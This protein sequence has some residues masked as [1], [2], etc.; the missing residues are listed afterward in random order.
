MNKTLTNIS[1][2]LLDFNPISTE[3]IIV[4]LDKIEQAVKLSS[5]I[6]EESRQWQT[7]LNS[8]ALFGL[9]EWLQQ[10]GTDFTIN[11]KKCSIFNPV[12]SNS[13]PAVCHL[14]I[15]Q[16][17]VCLITIGNII[18]EEISIP[19]AVLD[20]PEFYHHIYVVVEVQEEL[21]IVEIYGFI[22]HQDLI[23]NQT[24]ANLVPDTD[25][26][27]SVP[28]N[29][30]DR[31]TN[32]LLLYFRCLD[33]AGIPL[34]EIPANTNNLATAK[35]ELGKLLP[36]LSEQNLWEIFNWQQGATILRHYELLQWIYD[37]QCQK[38]TNTNQPLETTINH[39]EKIGEN[40]EKSLGYLKKYL[41]DLLNLLT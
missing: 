17:E 1:E 13:I 15:N 3:S 36:Q 41:P 37:W 30:F 12:L 38:V 9:E 40:P 34:P 6:P 21:E 20:L 23:Q 35:V 29:W 2:Y 33:L 26:N 28:L 10:R 22:S 24:A 16:F 18:D 31:E 4:P 25:W 32:N 19:R 11:S 14:N 39:Q 5:K 27:Y 7:Y 8:L